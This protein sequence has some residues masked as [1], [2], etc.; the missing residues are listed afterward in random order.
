METVRH[1]F[2]QPFPA[3]NSWLRNVRSAII[4]A[5]IVFFIIFFLRPFGFD[6]VPKNYL[7]GHALLFGAVTFTITAANLLLLPTLLPKTFAEI[8]WTTGKEFL[9]MMWHIVTIS[10]ANVLLTHTLYNWDIS[11]ETFF[12]FLRYTFWVGIF[13]IVILILLKYIALLKKHQQTAHLMEA[14]LFGELEEKKQAHPVVKLTGD[15]QNEVLEV[16]ANDVLY[17]SAA[18]NYIQVFYLKNDLTASVFIRST[19]KNA[20]ENLSG[21]SQFFRCHRTYLVNLQ[22]IVRVSGNAQGLKLHLPGSSELIPVSRSLNQQLKLQM[23]RQKY[24]TD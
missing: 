12:I 14:T 20:E 5:S 15:Y 3:Y 24:T 22:K 1:L 18:D 23:Q 8:H 17:I 11:F 13:P 2:I 9:M 21:L 16:P 10:L 19:L 7:F 6:R 4:A